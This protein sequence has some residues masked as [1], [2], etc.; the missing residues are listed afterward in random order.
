MQITCMERA[1]GVKKLDC[2]LLGSSFTFTANCRDKFVMNTVKGKTLG[3]EIDCVSV[4]LCLFELCVTVLFLY[5]FY[6]YTCVN[7]PCELCMYL[8]LSP[9]F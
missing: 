1:L 5:V 7:K 4:C 2:L 6:E 3:E 9:R 8:A